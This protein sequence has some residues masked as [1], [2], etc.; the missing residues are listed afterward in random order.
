MDKYEQSPGY[1]LYRNIPSNITRQR[2][3]ELG[4]IIYQSHQQLL[5]KLTRLSPKSLHRVLPSGL[6]ESNLEQIQEYFEEENK[7]WRC[8]KLARQYLHRTSRK[9]LHLEE[10]KSTLPE[11]SLEQKKKIDH[12]IYL[13]RR[14]AK[15][16]KLILDQLDDA[17]NEL[18]LNHIPIVLKGSYKTRIG[19][20][21]EDLL[22]EGYLGL[23]KTAERYDP[24]KGNL[25]STYS[26]L[27]VRQTLDRFQANTGRVVRLPVHVR[28]ELKRIYDIESG[29]AHKLMRPPTSEETLEELI[30]LGI[31][32]TD[33]K[34]Q[35][36]RRISTPAFSL[37]QAIIGV[38]SEDIG[39]LSEALTNASALEQMEQFEINDSLYKIL[40]KLPNIIPPCL[41]WMKWD[42]DV[43]IFYHKVG[44]TGPENPLDPQ[45]TKEVAAKVG[46]SKPGVELVLR[47]INEAISNSKLGRE[48]KKGLNWNLS[49]KNG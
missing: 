25:F 28:G 39:L 10:E 19:T 8:S 15:E 35:F 6:Q 21:V 36:Y 46:L 48:I 27:W 29:L 23:V 14:N 49:K 33:K 43:E 9:I 41:Q 45:S 32:I 2:E 11:E 30:K 42:R 1:I 37:D 18:T 7:W 40:E 22:Q 26:Q 16:I 20:E 44:Y 17:R 4:Q 31:K 13:R 38:E 24:R 3:E 5:D 47:K 12:K 34:Y